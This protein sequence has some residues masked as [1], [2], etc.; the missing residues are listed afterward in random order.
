MKQ[1]ALGALAKMTVAL[2]YCHNARGEWTAETNK[3]QQ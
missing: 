3:D 2:Q 1:I